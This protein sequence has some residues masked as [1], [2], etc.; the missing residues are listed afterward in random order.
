[1]VRQGYKAEI[2]QIFEHLGFVIQEGPE[3]ETEFNNFTALN[4]PADHPSRD[5]FDTFY[6]KQTDPTDKTANLLLRSHTSPTQ[7]PLPSTCFWEV[8]SLSGFFH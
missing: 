8:C 7:I 1:M 6:L 3:I 2:C 5:G 4:I